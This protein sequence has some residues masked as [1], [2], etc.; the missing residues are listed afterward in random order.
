ML[1]VGG[2][3][4]SLL[5]FDHLIAFDEIY[6]NFV[7]K[8]KPLGEIRKT[9]HTLTCLTELLGPVCTQKK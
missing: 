9:N 4:G 8:Y 3:G 5:I 2:R 7:E 6:I 1:E